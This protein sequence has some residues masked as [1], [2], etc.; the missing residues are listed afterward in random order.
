[1]K[2]IIVFLAAGKSSRFMSTSKWPKALYPY[3]GETWLERSI[4]QCSGLDI[5]IITGHHHQLFCE[6]LPEL[7]DLFL[8]NENYEKGAFSSIQKAI[9]NIDAKQYLIFPI[10]SVFPS[11]ALLEKLINA[12]NDKQIIIPKFEEKKGHPVVIRR[13]FAEKLLHL[14]LKHRDS[15]LDHQIHNLEQSSPEEIEYIGAEDSSIFYNF[16]TQ[17]KLD[18]YLKALNFIKNDA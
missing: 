2:T 5:V 7:Q 12:P 9:K 11:R 4:K 14:D 6:T 17:D 8:Y 18:T 3:Q 1:V 13:P 15:R 16:N 10:D